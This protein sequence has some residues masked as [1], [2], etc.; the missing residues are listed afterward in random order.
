MTSRANAQRSN[1]SKKGSHLG[2]KDA[3]VGKRAST[4]ALGDPRERSH[5]EGSV[6]VAPGASPVGG[7]EV[8]EAVEPTSQQV[9]GST[10][11]RE[12]TATEN[13]QSD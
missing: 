12:T 4:H 9:P 3:W 13:V 10:A 7:C 6:V 8:Q 11:E 5:V 1:W 2:E